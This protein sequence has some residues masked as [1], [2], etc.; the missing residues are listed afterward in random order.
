MSYDPPWQ[1]RRR[2]MLVRR[3]VWRSLLL[4]ALGSLMIALV[5]RSYYQ[6]DAEG[7]VERAVARVDATDPHWR[8]EDIL[9]QRAAVADEQN[10]ARIISS[11]AERMPS[12]WPTRSALTGFERGET[13]RLPPM[14]IPWYE[15]VEETAA[16]FRLEEDVVPALRGELTALAPLLAELRRLIDGPRTGRFDVQWERNYLGTRMAHLMHVRQLAGVLQYD[17]CLRTHDGDLM[18]GLA[19]CRGVLAAGRSLGS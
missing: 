1:R 13:E 9:A 6:F 14:T 11:V 15:R 8:W 4:S 17:A 19:S 3:W 10:A 7:E 16:N 18:G 2:G 12:N 5:W